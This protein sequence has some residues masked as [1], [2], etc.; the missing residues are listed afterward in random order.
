M[1][2]FLYANLVCFVFKSLALFDSRTQLFIRL[3]MEKLSIRQGEGHF[4]P[5]DID[6]TDHYATP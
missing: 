5:Y 4:F 6:Q 1:M 3:K 2:C